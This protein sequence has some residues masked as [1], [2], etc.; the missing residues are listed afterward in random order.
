MKKQLIL[1]VFLITALIVKAQRNEVFSP[2]IQSL[3]I[4]VNDNWLAP[5]IVNLNSDDVLEISFD[6]LSHEYHRFQYVISH[7]NA[8]WTDLRY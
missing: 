6:E 8:D 3:Q 1:C 5:P 7:H 2:N 4:K